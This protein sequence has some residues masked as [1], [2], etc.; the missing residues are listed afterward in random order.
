MLNL[1]EAIQHCKEKV[2]ENNRKSKYYAET[3]AI[4]DDYRLGMAHDCEECAKD[5]KQLAS[6]L[7]ELKRRRKADRRNPLSD[8]RPIGKG[9]YLTTTIHH[10][11]YCDYW[12]GESFDRTEA[13]IAWM[14]LPEPY[15]GK[16]KP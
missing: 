10:E 7:E 13:V 16:E 14:P 2:D 6:W 5:H 4:D 8:S 12:N 1:D 3:S 9:L 15:E 11:V